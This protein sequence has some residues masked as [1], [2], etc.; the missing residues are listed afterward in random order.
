[1]DCSLCP[2]DFSD[3][4]TRV[5]SLSLLQGIFPTQGSNPDLPVCGRILYQLICVVLVTQ[6][7]QTLCDPMDWWTVAH[8]GLLTVRIFQTWILEWVALS[9]SRALRE[10]GIELRSPALQMDSLLYELTGKPYPIF[11]EV[12]KIILVHT[13]IEFDKRI[14]CATCY[15]DIY[16]RN[17]T[18]HVAYVGFL[19]QCNLCLL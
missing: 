17:W 19:L 6:S 11:V 2:W 8:Q 13:C 4:N 5:R 1:M 3:K 16:K 7:C 9:F 10:P 18:L 14:S 12:Y 15:T